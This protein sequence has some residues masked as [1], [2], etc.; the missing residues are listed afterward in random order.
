MKYLIIFS[1]ILASC[2]PQFHIN[3]AK[4]HTAKAIDKGAI[5]TTSNDTLVIND[6]I[7]TDRTFTINDTVYIE[8][9]KTVESVVYQ[10][11][12]IRYITKKDK[13][14]EHRSVKRENKRDYK[15]DKSKEKTKRV[16]VRKENKRSWLW[17]LLILVIGLIIG[18]SLS[19]KLN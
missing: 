9:I 13:R 19:N 18:Y 15:L 14:K 12:E 5:L 4:K 17:G 16:I 6:T 7:V 11:G 8:R 1:L 2:S 10:V 3:K